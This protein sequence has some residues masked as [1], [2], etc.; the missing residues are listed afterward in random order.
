VRYSI[1]GI[2]FF[3]PELMA[4]IPF[5][6]QLTGTRVKESDRCGGL[7]SCCTNGAVFL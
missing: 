5:F 1:N 3:V 6:D 7:F 4:A 2:A